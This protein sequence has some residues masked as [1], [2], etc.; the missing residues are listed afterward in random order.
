[1]T[2]AKRGHTAASTNANRSAS[3]NEKRFQALVRAHS[4]LVWNTNATGEFTE[5]QPAWQAYTGQTWEECRGHGGFEKINPHDR[6]KVQAAWTRAVERKEGYQIEF[7]VWH[8]QS[9]S[10]RWCASRAVPIFGDSGE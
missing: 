1:M 7:R 3:M 8:D 6:D 9:K 10:W 4:A 5:P 2:E